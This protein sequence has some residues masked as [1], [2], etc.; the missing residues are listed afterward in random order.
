ML[1]ASGFQRAAFAGVVSWIN[2][3]IMERRITGFG[4]LVLAWVAGSRVSGGD[5]KFGGLSV[6]VVVVGDGVV[7]V[8]V[9]SIIVVVGV[10]GSSELS[11]VG[12]TFGAVGVACAGGVALEVGGGGGGECDGGECDGVGGVEGGASVSVGSCGACAMGSLADFFRW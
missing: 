5:G 1:R 11:V 9:G 10:R 2:R 3:S 6:L 4:G 7:V 8:V 12:L